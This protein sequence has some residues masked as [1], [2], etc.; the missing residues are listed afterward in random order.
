MALT[1]RAMQLRTNLLRP[2]KGT[3]SRGPH[4][5]AVPTGTAPEGDAP[6][7][8]DLLET[9]TQ[10]SRGDLPRGSSDPE[11]KG[12][13]DRGER[14]PSIYPVGRT[15]DSCG[16]VSRHGVSSLY[17]LALCLPESACRRDQAGCVPVGGDS[18]VPQAGDTAG[19]GSP[20]SEAGAAPRP[21]LSI[22]IPEI[23]NALVA[24]ER[25]QLG[26]AH[27]GAILDL[28]GL[29]SILG[30]ASPSDHHHAVNG[31][32]RVVRD[33]GWAYVLIDA[34]DAWTAQADIL[35]GPDD[36]VYFRVSVVQQQGGRILLALR[37]RRRR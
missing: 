36:R 12:E 29:A 14:F 33:C 37:H 34:R 9:G 10:G 32:V 25:V 18:T 21:I 17:G 5:K 20:R 28:T 13:G 22:T 23:R 26:N 15:T 19:Q 2:P 4:V 11:C 1:K 6:R 7:G 31:L 35:G 8:R 24:R 30:S 16:G 3:R 27:K